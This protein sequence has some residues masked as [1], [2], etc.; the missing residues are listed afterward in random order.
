[1]R[2][3]RMLVLVVAILALTLSAAFSQTGLPVFAGHSQV[4][5]A[6]W[7]PKVAM[8]PTMGPTEPS[9]RRSSVEAIGEAMR[10]EIHLRW[11]L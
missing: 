6:L 1:M 8:V 10:Y 7:A 5:A 3:C 11:A 2:A 9:P 4:A